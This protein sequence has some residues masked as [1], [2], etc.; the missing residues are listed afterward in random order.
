MMLVI[1]KF[2]IPLAFILALSFFVGA[3]LAP[4][5]LAGQVQV[6]QC[7]DKE[8]VPEVPVENEKCFD[9][10]CPTCQFVINT[11]AEY[12]ESLTSIISVYSW[13]VSKLVPSGFI[14]SI[15]YPPELA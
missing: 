1:R 10:N 12:D 15:D 4:A 3:T 5:V 2:M 13:L 14:R 9:C 7:C 6:E 8:D 11:Q